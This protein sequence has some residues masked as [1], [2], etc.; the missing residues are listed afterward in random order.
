MISQAFDTPVGCALV[1]VLLG[2][3]LAALFR[4]TCKGGHCIVIKSPNV[5]NVEKNT[6]RYNQHCYKYKAKVV[7]CP[8]GKQSSA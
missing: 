2:L 7:D 8:T 4:E 1:S 6:Y 3:G 5:H